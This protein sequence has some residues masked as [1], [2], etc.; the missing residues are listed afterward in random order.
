MRFLEMELKN[1]RSFLG[2]YK[3]DFANDDSRN[4][5]VFVG[6]N[7]SGKTALLN[8][9]TWVLFGETTA[10]FRRPDDLFNHTALSLISEGAVDNM[11]VKLIFDHDGAKYEV[12]RSLEAERVKDKKYPVISPVKFSATKRKGTTEAIDQERIN[13]ILPPGLHP[14][15]FFPSE[16]IGKDIDQNDA[17]SIRASMSRAI[18]VLLGIE[19]YDNALKIISRTLTK[20]LKSPS[21]TPKDATIIAAEDEM[22]NARQEWEAADKR[23]RELP[24]IIDRT[25]RVVDKLNEALE[26][27]DAHSGAVEKMNKITSEISSENDNIERIRGDQVQ[28]INR[29]CAALLSKEIFTDAKA[30][31]DIA[32]KE[33]K[34]PPKVSAGLLDE[35]INVRQKCICGRKLGEIERIELKSLR[36]FTLEDAI[37]EIASDLR[38]RLPLL[39]ETDEGSV[40]K[41]LADKILGFEKEALVAERNLLSLKQKKKK[42]IDEQPEVSFSDPGKTREAWQKQHRRLAFLQEELK[43]I[44]KEL[45]ELELVKKNVEKKYRAALQRQ[46]NTQA[47]GEARGLLTS[48]E[49]TLTKIQEIVRTCAK[50]DV[51]RAM[52]DFYTPLLLKNYCVSLTD[53][54]RYEIVDFT[55][56]RTVGASS[57][58]VALATFAFVGAIAAL[59]PSYAR[60]EQLLPAGDGKSVGSLRADAANAYPVV[61]D[62]PYSPFGKEYADQFSQALPNL[63]PQS[64]I[65]VRED[66]LEYVNAMLDGKRVGASYV[67]QLHSGGAE[68]KDLLWQNNKYGYVININSDE[69]SHTKL[70]RLPVD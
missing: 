10:G 27:S 47:I 21:N 30:A 66:Q 59:M 9:F 43:Q 44:S 60:L 53:D 7:G 68:D 12:T 33:G 65:I 45:P 14:F 70:T 56:S 52:N 28:A 64:V 69:A 8:A 58:E 39:I 16:N 19:R 3:I 54:F 51:E 57:S 6:Q 26:Q 46:A 22:N 18:D 50:K 1:W 29:S 20:H 4:I 63:L 41:S 15:F 23:K 36:S 38:G 31:L 37:A 40:D 17:A 25:Q 61:L 49:E 34:I 42:L 2:L 55:T 62:A 13:A 11:F 24:G 35:L 48:V 32:H 67:L 5:T